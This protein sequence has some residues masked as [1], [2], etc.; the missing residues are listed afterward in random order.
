L[1]AY[2]IAAAAVTVKPA[3]VAPYVATYPI[4][5]AFVLWLMDLRISLTVLHA[6]ANITVW[7]LEL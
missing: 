5:I 7:K 6:I 2:L 4:S 3:T 1:A